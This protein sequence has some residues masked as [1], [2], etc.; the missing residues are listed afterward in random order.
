M[1]GLLIKDLYLIEQRKQTI[2]LFAIIS[3]I[4]GFSTGGSLIVGYMAFFSAILAVGT[5]SYD[6]A[7][8]GMIFL[9]TLPVKPRTY[10]YSKYAFG[11]ICCALGWLLSIV[12][13][14]AVNT[15]R[16]ETANSLNDI[17]IS[18]I[19]IPMI[20]ITLDVMIPVQLKYGAERSR[21]VILMVYG[22]IAAVVLLMTKVLKGTQIGDMLI[23]AIDKIPAAV[24][25]IAAVA[26]CSVLSFVSIR[27]SV[28]AVEMK[29]Y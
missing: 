22:A 18:L 26:I 17:L 2:F 7:D 9:M 4:L 27:I 10:A 24:Y 13:L 11:A 14:L 8:N 15:I 6:E 5:I 25:I 12:L 16:Q 21:T 3:A 1:K 20:V 23:A 19:I 29:T 28:R